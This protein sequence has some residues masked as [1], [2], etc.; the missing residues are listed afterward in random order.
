MTNPL[1]HL[2][3]L[4]THRIVTVA[5][6]VCLVVDDGSCKTKR[7]VEVRKALGEKSASKAEGLEGQPQGFLLNERIRLEMLEGNC[8]TICQN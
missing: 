2:T 3:I 8:G 1:D 6:K 5:I 4:A 7:Y